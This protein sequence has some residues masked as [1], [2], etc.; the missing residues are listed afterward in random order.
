MLI[1]KKEKA[2]MGEER[3]RMLCQQNNEELDAMLAEY[4]SSEEEEEDDFS[5]FNIEDEDNYFTMC[6]KFK[7]NF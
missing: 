3:M 4:N 1:F 2:Y 5:W 6:T 7:V